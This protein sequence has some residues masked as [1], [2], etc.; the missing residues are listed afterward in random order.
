M[1]LSSSPQSGATDSHTTR[2][3]TRGSPHIKN[4]VHVGC[5]TGGVDELDAEIERLIGLGATIAWEEQFPP[6]VTAHYRNVVLRDPEGNEFC[7]GAGRPP[8]S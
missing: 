3:T 6:E 5:T 8:S 7:L 4:R 2:T 1:V